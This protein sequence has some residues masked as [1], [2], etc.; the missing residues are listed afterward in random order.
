LQSLSKS[1]WKDRIELVVFGSSQPENAVELGFKAH[2]LGN[3]ADG[4][5]LATVYAA[6]DVFVAP[7]VYDNLP[8]TVMKL[9]L[10]ASPASHLILGDC[11]IRSNTA[12][13]AI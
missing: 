6:A 11:R 5:S 12:Q 4:I 8:N 2:Y 9:E 13:M 7:C 10:A 1:G 3:L